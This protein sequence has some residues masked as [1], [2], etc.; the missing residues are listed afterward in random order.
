V[1]RTDRGWSGPSFIGLGTFLDTLRSA[2]A[3]QAGM[4]FSAEGRGC[5]QSFG[6]IEVLDIVPNGNTIQRIH[7]RFEHHCESPTNF[8]LKG[9][10]RIFQ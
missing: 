3:T 7:V 8:P 2:T 1:A 9:E 5:N 10:L 6:H 4:S